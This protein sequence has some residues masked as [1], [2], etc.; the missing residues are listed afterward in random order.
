MGPVPLLTK[1]PVTFVP[2]EIATMTA[3]AVVLDLLT[4]FTT[5][6]LLLQLLFTDRC[7]RNLLLLLLLITELLT[8]YVEVLLV[9]P[10][11]P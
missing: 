5:N 9:V 1:V 2:L 7:L 4:L 11:V 8:I 10:I 3:G 6:C